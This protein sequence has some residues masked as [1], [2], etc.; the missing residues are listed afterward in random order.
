MRRYVILTLSF[1]LAVVIGA[2]A[3]GAQSM[4]KLPAALALARSADSPGQVTFNHDTH[5]DATRPDCTSCHPKEFS[6]LG[7]KARAKTP[8]T[9]QQFEQGRQCGR[10]HN[11]EKAFA[12]EDDCTFCHASE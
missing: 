2:R 11:G 3:T 12:L 9:H 6:I 5:V 1:A 10:C 4:P 8:L 7:A